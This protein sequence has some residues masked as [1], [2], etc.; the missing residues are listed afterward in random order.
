MQALHGK[1]PPPN[2]NP[3]EAPPKRHA[4]HKLVLNRCEAIH[5]LIELGLEAKK[6]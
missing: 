3:K 4:R 2:G 1:E 5:R 6:A